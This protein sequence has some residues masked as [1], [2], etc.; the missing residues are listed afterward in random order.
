MSNF[1][2]LLPEGG[3]Q[4]LACDTLWQSSLIGVAGLF[5]ARFLARQSATRAWVLLLTIS[6]CV[7]APLATLAARQAGIGVLG[8]ASARLPVSAPATT[9]SVETG[10]KQQDAGGG[11]ELKIAVDLM[12][13]PIVA[14][15]HG[16]IANQAESRGGVDAASSASADAQSAAVSL[17]VQHEP[18][19]ATLRLSEIDL[20][21]PVGFV[22]LAASSVL[23]GRLLLS[24]I[25]TRRLLHMAA[26]CEDEWLQ[27][28]AR[29]A[30]Q[31]IGLKKA[32]TLLVSA[33]V[34]TPTVL[35]FRSARLLIPSDSSEKLRNDNHIDW[36][37][38][39]THEL[40]HV[41]RRDGWSRLWSELALIAM[42]LQ[43]LVWLARRALRIASEEAC[44]DFA[45][46]AGTNPVDL[47]DTLMAWINVSSGTRTVLAIG[48]SSSKARA[49][50]LLALRGKPNGK[51]NQI[52]RWTGIPIA[53]ILLGGLA[54][55]QTPKRKGD[56]NSAA[57][58]PPTAASSTP[59]SPISPGLPADADSKDLRKASEE[60]IEKAIAEDPLIALYNQ[61][62][63][64]WKQVL[65]TTLSKEDLKSV[66]ERIKS[67]EEKINDRKTEL[68]TR[69]AQEA[70]GASERTPTNPATPSIVA[71]YI[72]EPPDVLEITPIR[73]IPKQP[74]RVQP[75]DK[76]H[77][78]VEGAKFD[79]PIHGIFKVDSSG[80]VV[81]GPSY[82]SVK[83]SGLLRHEAQEVVK[84][85]LEAV[86]LSP[87]V[88]LT[89]DESRIETGITG[90]HLVG[91][92]G[93]INFGIYG[94]VKVGGQTTEAARKSIEDKLA[95]SFNNPIVSVE[96]AGYNSKVFYIVVNGSAGDSILKCPMTGNETF[97]DAMS[98]LGR[99]ANMAGAKIWISR[100]DAGGKEQRIDV[101]W[102]S[103]TEGAAANPAILPGDRIIVQGP[104][105]PKD[106][107]SDSVEPTP[108]MKIPSADFDVNFG[109]PVLVKSVPE[110]GADNVD[111]NLPEIRVT[112]SRKMADQSWSW[113][114]T[115]EESFPE[116]TDK[117]HYLDDH[118]TCVLPVKL[119]PGKTYNIWL[120]WPEDNPDQ[121]VP[122]NFKDIKGR[123]SVP[124][125][126]VFKTKAAAEAR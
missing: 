13:A 1:L 51:L 34:A 30:A 49:L 123:S 5:A 119:Q 79:E 20:F 28:A 29:Q 38:A 8:T 80:E 39:F 84:T 103:V 62:M 50:R 118:R 108:S 25:A 67:Y 27:A 105:W 90:K 88:A 95:A 47:A 126:L 19:S 122:R 96:V 121:Y 82:G 70:P 15:K 93:T 109:S 71:Q 60:K 65:D 22:W 120:N 7:I 68:R 99:W 46:A 86:L 116:T 61:R 100:S 52:W 81:L 63:Q 35:A 59:T 23:V 10:A 37:A 69:I 53:L 44:D 58:L 92:D 98:Q 74:V 17:L 56:Q 32:P 41:V 114:H 91:P 48:M 87:E 125:L 16:E 33:K 72:I 124:Y 42:P 117:P 43:P 78:D 102:T 11:D 75:G 76:L 57:T 77:I 107:K 89:I 21:R 54:V 24:L 97:L 14:D 110:A 40:A 115:S 26:L 4:R 9:P 94:A 106:G 3:W 83:V 85:H 111:P 12:P 45:V 104:V 64:E 36:F 31:R 2:S 18:N 101:D 73:L 55:A 113:C 6:G 66:K 112:F